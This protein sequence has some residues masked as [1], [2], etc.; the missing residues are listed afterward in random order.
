M[1]FRFDRMAS[2]GVASVKLARWRRTQTGRVPILMYHGIND[3]LGTRHPYFETSTSPAVFRSQMQVLKKSGYRVLSV[4][5]AMCAQH[6][7]SGADRLVAITFDDGYADFYEEALPVLVDFGFAAT[8]YIVTGATSE[9]RLVKSGK[10]FM[11][12]TDVRELLK[13][14]IRVGSH[15]VNHCKL[16]EMSHSRAEDEIRRSKETLENKL[17]ALVE[18]FAY[19]YA[20]PEHNTQ[21]IK[22]TRQCL[23]L[24]G[25]KNAVSTIVGTASKRT[26]PYLLP[27]LPVNTFDDD[28]FL[29]AKLE[30]GY[31][32]LHSLQFAKKLYVERF[33]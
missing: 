16:W 15:T 26:D 24:C 28:A 13:Y 31:E 20:F 10:R 3:T 32:W 19:P 11:S 8:M 14:N 17:G 25:Y 7:D 4:E 29:R 5:S 9:C 23:Q 12:W 27:R 1:K 33:T 6:F 30:G 21:F 18:S 22:H 2:L